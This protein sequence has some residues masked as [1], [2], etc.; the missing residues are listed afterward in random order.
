MTRKLL[1]KR[2]FLFKGKVLNIGEAFETTERHARD[3][4]LGKLAVDQE[5]TE[6]TQDKETA[7]DFESMKMPELKELLD[8]RGIQYPARAS[9]ADLVELAEGL[10]DESVNTRSDQEPAED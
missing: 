6:G 5:T 3:L 1:A 8:E 10:D 9:K 2:N 7:T 4:L